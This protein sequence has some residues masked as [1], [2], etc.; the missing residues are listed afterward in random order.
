LVDAVVGVFQMAVEH[1]GVRAE[2]EFV[3]R[4]MD[5]QPTGGVGL[6]LAN[7]IADLGMKDFRPAAGQAAEAGV[8]QFRQHFADGAAGQVCEPVQFD[9][10]QA[11]RCSRGKCS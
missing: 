10:R 9:R 6:V 2:P 3:G 8:A 1:R 11:L 4:A 5:F 7:L